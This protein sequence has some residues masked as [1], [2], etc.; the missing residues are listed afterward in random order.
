MLKILCLSGDEN[1]RKNL[2]LTKDIKFA[3]ADCIFI[4]VTIESIVFTTI[5]QISSLSFG[6]FLSSRACLAAFESIFSKTF[7]RT[8]QL[9]LEIKIH[10]FIINQHL[11]LS[12]FSH[13][14]SWKLMDC[15]KKF[16]NHFCWIT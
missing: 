8:L 3:R 6:S 15:L 9:L 10:T 11:L 4:T 13:V 14:D 1:N 16:E 12:S 2:T 7:K 5:T